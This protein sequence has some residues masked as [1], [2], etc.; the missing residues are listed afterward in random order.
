MLLLLSAATALAHVNGE[1][2]GIDIV[3]PGPDQVDA[4]GPAVSASFGLVVKDGDAHRWICHEAITSP[5]ALFAPRYAR[6]GDGVFLGAIPDL[7]QARE[8][9][10]TLYRSAD[11]CGW[12]PVSGL[13]GQVVNRMAFDPGDPSVA[14]AITANS[15]AP[16]GIYRSTDGGLSFSLALEVEDRLFSTVRFSRRTAGQVWATGLRVDADAGTSEHWVYHSEDGGL[17]W[18]EQPAPPSDLDYYFFDLVAVSPT[19]AGE[20]WFVSGYYGLDTLYHT[21]DGGETFDVVLADVAG[22]LID[23]VMDDSGGLWIAASGSRMFY[24][25]DAQSFDLVESPPGGYG[26]SS[27]GER[28]FATSLAQLTLILYGHTDA[29]GE[30]SFGDFFYLAD[31]QPP[32]SCPED[33]EVV[34]ICEPLWATL[35]GNLPTW[36]TDTADTADPD[37]SDTGGKDSDGGG[38][39]SR[40]VVGLVGLGLLALGRR[41]RC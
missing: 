9:G 33:S 39:R 23:G 7:A 14:L 32:P 15:G 36:I 22:D 1:L 13:S 35:E 37:G 20:A 8:D 18:T 26:I 28:I 5:D 10:E 3:L 40:S 4:F 21:D 16:S 24:A 12:D 27:D 17:T 11:G 41:R 30:T 25:P 19:V 2:E 34:Q 6:S 31:L 38:C 29:L